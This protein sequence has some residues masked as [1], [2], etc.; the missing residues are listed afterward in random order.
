MSTQAHIRPIVR[1]REPS[2]TILEAAMSHGC[3]PLQARVLASRLPENVAPDI[4]RWI[5][6]RL[7]QL[8][9]PWL[10]PD[11]EPAVEAIVAAITSPDRMLALVVDHDA[12][13][14]SALA[15]MWTALV[16]VFGLPEHRVM[17]F[18]SHRMKEGYGV[19][20]ALT[21][22]ILAAC[23]A[24]SLIITADQ[25]ST[26]E[27]RFA[28]LVEHGH[29]VVV[30]DHHEIPEAGPPAS[31]LACVNPTRDDS[32]FPDRYVA[33]CHV[34]WLVMCAV[35]ARLIERGHL[36]TATPTLAGLLDYVAVGTTADAVSFARSVNNRA[37]VAYGL[38]L[39]NLRPRP[40]WQAYRALVNKDGR[41]TARDISHG[42]A[43]RVNA[44]SRLGDAM[45]GADYLCADTVAEAS[46]LVMILDAAN[47]QRKEI[48]KGLLADAQAACERQYG[49]PARVIHLPNGHAGVHGIV[50]S[51]IVEATARPTVC[52]SP[53]EGHAGVL[54]GS[55]RSVPG[56]HLRD[57][58]AWVQ[59]ALGDCPIS[60]GGHA[61]AAG[62]L[63]REEDLPRFTAAFGR[64]I[65]IQHPLI[66]D[67]VPIVWTDGALG[68]APG[69]TELEEIEAL[70]PYGRDFDAPVFEDE[71]LVAQARPVGDG[72]HLKL[73]LVASDGAP[74]D[75]IWFRALEPG[76]PAP[77]QP[78]RKARLAYSVDRNEFRGRVSVN[79]IVQ[80]MGG[81]G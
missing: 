24:P 51:R 4:G 8:D 47:Q 41:F 6:P 60:F 21:D 33:G 81:D 16:D 17:R 55:L 67:Q 32:R 18:L 66:H 26:D 1:A 15:V 49:R 74:V 62:C 2:Q 30:S 34:A 78:G 23:P 22:R 9:S 3:T 5:E 77:V 48:E 29:E 50:A 28:R 72:S 63:I 14:S 43:P 12:D 58:L 79:L 25:G 80:A 20:D 65:T 46:R 69:F 56:V 52:F 40:A 7:S 54:T 59:H 68:R 45:L 31:A 76:G 44:R 38:S 39:M 35:R 73:A 75:A 53:K 64:A 42:I 71:F 37:I 10:L 13:G 36:D 70:E 61:M 19:S 27:A 57:A 11:I